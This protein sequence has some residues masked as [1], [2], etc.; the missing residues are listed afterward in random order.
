MRSYFNTSQ[1]KAKPEK[2]KGEQAPVA[3]LNEHGYPNH[4][5]PR[6][7]LSLI[8]VFKIPLSD[9]GVLKVKQNRLKKAL[10]EF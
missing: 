4:A 1:L 8:E 5:I 6:H 10:Y 2:G 9:L 7:F 3:L